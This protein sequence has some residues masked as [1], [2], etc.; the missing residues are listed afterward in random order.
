MKL[1]IVKRIF[2]Y[3]LNARRISRA[4]KTSTSFKCPEGSEWGNGVVSWFLQTRS[5]ADKHIYRTR[6]SLSVVSFGH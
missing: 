5:I 4:V 3:K 1:D 2:G 6:S